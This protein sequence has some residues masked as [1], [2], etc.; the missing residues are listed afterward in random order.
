MPEAAGVTP[1][2]EKAC[3]VVFATSARM[4]P[5]IWP[6]LQGMAWR[7]LKGRILCR[8]LHLEY[9]VRFECQIWF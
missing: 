8:E 2:L 5:Q 9:V 4:A 3:R 7:Q 1:P 6:E